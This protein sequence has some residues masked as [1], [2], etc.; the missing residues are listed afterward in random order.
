[1]EKNLWST[2]KWLMDKSLISQIKGDGVLGSLQGLQL[3]AFNRLI[4]VSK[5]NRILSAGKSL[6]GNALS[7]EGLI[8]NLFEAIIKKPKSPDISKQRLQIHFV[9]RIDELID[10]ERL[11]PTIKSHLLYTKNKI[12]KFAKRGGGSHYKYLKTISE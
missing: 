11:N 9:E 6:E 8:D 10:E 12:H 7:V 4:S 2:Q 1:M 5:L 3:S